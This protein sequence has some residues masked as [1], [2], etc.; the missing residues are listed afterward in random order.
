MGASP[1]A[2]KGKDR[3]RNC[4]VCTSFGRQVPSDQRTEPATV[5]GSGV[6]DDVAKVNIPLGAPGVRNSGPDR[7]CRAAHEAPSFFTQFSLHYCLLA[8]QQYISAQHSN[9][10]GGN[11]SRG[12]IYHLE[13]C[14]QQLSRCLHT[15]CACSSCGA[16]CHHLAGFLR[17]WCK[18]LTRHKGWLQ[19][20]S[21]SPLLCAASTA[22]AIC[23]C[24]TGLLWTAELVLTSQLSFIQ[25][26]LDASDVCPLCEGQTS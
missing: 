7:S 25:V 11:N 19:L 26:S 10:V 20:A 18:A 13:V 2:A 14:L 22:S 9:A 17:F 4:R 15:S 1:Y 24:C 21:M 16:T 8:L 3:C 12:P 23:F 6:R 5:I